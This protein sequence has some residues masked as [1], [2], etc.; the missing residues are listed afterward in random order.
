MSTS[1]DIEPLENSAHSENQEEAPPLGSWK[2]MY[3]L[4]L[5]NLVVLIVLFYAFTRAFD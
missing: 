1:S 4:V 2:R 3:A 5:A